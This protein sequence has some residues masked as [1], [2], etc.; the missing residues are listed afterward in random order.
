MLDARLPDPIYTCGMTDRAFRVGGRWPPEQVSSRRRRDAICLPASGAPAER[1]AATLP[2][3]NGGLR[4]AAS[5]RAYGHGA[6]AAAAR[7]LRRLVHDL[8]VSGNQLRAWMVMPADPATLFACSGDAYDFRSGA[9]EGPITLWR[10]RDTGYHWTQLALPATSGTSCALAVAPDNPQRIAFVVTD[11][12]EQRACDRLTLYLSEDAGD[13]WTHVAHTS[14]APAGSGASA[15]CL[16]LVSARYL[17]VWYSYGGGI[18]GGPEVA[19]LERGEA[20]G[21]WTRIDSRFGADALYIPWQL[22]DGDSLMASVLLSGP[23]TQRA[24]MALS[25]GSRMM[26]GTAGRMSAGSQRG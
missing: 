20:H 26:R 11:Y 22:G 18:G 23:T 13:T 2:H 4:C 19:L 16:V 3:G 8:P 7:L 14:I 1:A 17:Y 12:N 9:S 25:S 5:F 6:G 21:T 24:P 10:T 15:Q